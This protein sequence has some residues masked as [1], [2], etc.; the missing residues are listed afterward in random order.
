MNRRAIAVLLLGGCVHAQEVRRAVPVGTGSLDGY[1]N[2]A[3][4]GQAQ[5]QIEIRRAVPASQE[6]LEPEVSAGQPVSILKAIPVEPSQQPVDPPPEP[7]EVGVPTPD[8]IQ[9]QTPVPVPQVPV[10]TSEDED[11]VIRIAPG[12]QDDGADSALGRANSFFAKKMYDLAIPEYEVFLVQG[13][14]I[15]ARDAALFRLAESHRALKNPTAARAA[16]EKLLSEYQNG[17]FA[18]AGAYRL[19]GMLFDEKQFDAA[20]SQFDFA[21]REGKDTG[22]RLSSAY[23]AGRSHEAAGRII[24]AANRYEAVLSA[25]GK[26]DY[27]DNAAMALGGIQLKRGET[28]AALKTFEDLARTSAEDDVAASAAMEAGGL[29]AKEGQTALGLEFFSIAANRGDGEVKGAAL[30]QSLLLRYRNGDHA[31]VVANGREVVD[32]VNPERRPEV[33]KILAASLRE[34]GDNAGA[35]SVYGEVLAAPSGNADPEVGYQRLLALHAAGDNSLPDE[36]DEFVA[37]NP[38]PSLVASALLLKAESSFQK[39]DHAAAALAYEKAVAHPQLKDAQRPAAIYK[40]AWSLSESGNAPAAI[41]TYAAF[42]TEYPKDKLAAGA[43]LQSGLVRQKTQDLEGAVGDFNRVLQEH[44]LSA[45]VEV[46]LLQKALT[47]GQLKRNQEM[48]AAFR[49]LL[50][51]FPKTAAAAQANYWIGWV[52]YENNS[53]DEAVKRLEE[54]RRLDAETYGER[55]ALR[56]ILARYQQ[57]DLAG[58]LAEF[59]KTKGAPLPAEVLLWMADGYA[60]A[61]AHEKVEETLKPLLE[62][63]AALPSQGWLLLTKSRNELGAYNEAAD[64]ATRYLAG[65]DD[66]PSQARGYLARAEA[67]LGIRRLEEARRDIDQALFLQPEG[68]LNAEGRLLSGEAFFAAGDYDSAARSFMAVSVLTDD[69]EVTPQALR[70]AADAY[71]RMFNDEEARK[72]LEELRQRFPSSPLSKP[73]V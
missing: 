34:S 68:G 23:F 38:D 17:E 16:Y 62:N 69:P 48:D 1:E 37:G 42:V 39:N 63:G 59:E 64:A 51:K 67:L 14:N 56:I 55:A 28:A 73:S 13:G 10:S 72:A 29:A 30:L 43:L 32:A 22:V 4:I 50:E 20:S 44:P 19:G 11:G 53:M 35:A 33:L 45:E 49:Q 25:R 66:P 52:A 70:R 21:A 54:A 61:G 12:V 8:A 47:C 41:A 7:A 60:E 3:W 15:E 5:E 71:A 18:A 46:A 2:P 65:V 58:A 40:Q 36:I 27:R 6:P 26:N 24:D 31:G 9:E 57:Q